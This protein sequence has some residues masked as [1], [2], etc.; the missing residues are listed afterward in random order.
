MTSELIDLIKQVQSKI[1]DDSNMTWTH[2]DKP[3]QLKNELDQYIKELQAGDFRPL[4]ELKLLFLPTAT[5]QEHSISNGWADEYMELSEKFDKL[6]AKGQ[7][8]LFNFSKKI[9]S[10]Y[11]LDYGSII[12]QGFLYEMSDQG[13]MFLLDNSYWFYHDSKKYYVDKSLGIFD[14]STCSAVGHFE[15]SNWAVLIGFKDKLIW[16]DQEFKFKRVKPEPLHSIFQKQTWGHF[17]FQLSRDNENIIYKFK[18]DI[19]TAALGNPYVDKPFSGY[20]E[21][22]NTD[23]LI[24][25]AG[26]ILVERAL[27]NATD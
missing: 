1:A 2:Y 13:V 18:I 3:E 17:K 8:H 12:D 11:T 9:I 14:S 10:N 21:T 7:Y 19:P 4:E 6:N 16:Q 23:P 24:A 25:L 5:L 22:E 27:G 20:V 26:L 15:F